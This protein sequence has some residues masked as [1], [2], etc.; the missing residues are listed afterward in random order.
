MAR[1]SAVGGVCASRGVVSHTGLVRS[2]PGRT[3]HWG[4]GKDP[5]RFHV[6]TGEKPGESSVWGGKK[7]VCRRGTRHRTVRPPPPVGAIHRG[8]G[9]RPGLEW[10]QHNPLRER[11]CQ[12]DRMFTSGPSNALET[13]MIVRLHHTT[14][15][16]RGRDA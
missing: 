9:A 1:T 7:R 2:D 16:G 4:R 12:W 6:P 15:S 10:R 14:G 8:E 3:G 13:S 11:L 5:L